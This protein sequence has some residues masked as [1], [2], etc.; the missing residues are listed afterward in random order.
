M[1][2]RFSPRVTTLTWLLFAAWIVTVTV[3]GQGDPSADTPAAWFAAPATMPTDTFDLPFFDQFRSNGRLNVSRAAA[4]LETLSD[5]N[6]R[7]IP[8]F[9]KNGVEGLTGS[10][11][12][13]WLLQIEAKSKQPA[14]R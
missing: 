7:K 6:G 13:S 3:S 2:V 4:P 11:N 9:G 1:R 14:A 12:F 8:I 5:A 10:A